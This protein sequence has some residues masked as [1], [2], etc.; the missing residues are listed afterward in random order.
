MKQYI[1]IYCNMSDFQ[2]NYGKNQTSIIQ[3]ITANIP[4][5]KNLEKVKVYVQKC[6]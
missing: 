5:I 3:M 1:E 6:N 4:I 2:S